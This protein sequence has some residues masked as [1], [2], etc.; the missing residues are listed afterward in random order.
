M[1]LLLCKV[2]V[3]LAFGHCGPR[4]C[5]VNLH[6]RPT[7]LEWVTMENSFSG[8][9]LDVQCCMC[10]DMMEMTVIQSLCEGVWPQLGKLADRSINQKPRLPPPPR[11]VLV[12]VQ[13]QSS[14]FFVYVPLMC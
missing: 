12:S 4:V 1:V 13:N 8:R 5:V 10:G 7:A 9:L 6:V 11:F 2:V 14:V 3:V